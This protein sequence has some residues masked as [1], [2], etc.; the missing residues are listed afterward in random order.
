MKL[1]QFF[2]LMTA[3]MNDG[4][5]EPAEDEGPDAPVA[6]AEGVGDEGPA[7]PGGGESAGSEEEKGAEK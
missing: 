7:G 4:S 3:T 6:P 1:S 5:A 2:R